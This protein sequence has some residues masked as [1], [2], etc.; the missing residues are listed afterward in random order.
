L[1][2]TPLPAGAT[3]ATSL[4]VGWAVGVPSVVTGV[5][6]GVTLG[7]SA[8]L[9]ATAEKYRQRENYTLEALGNT[10]DSMQ[11]KRLHAGK[12][13]QTSDGIA[14]M[15]DEAAP[16]LVSL[17][18]ARRARVISEADA[19]ERASAFAV[20]CA[21]DELP[22]EE[23]LENAE[24]AGRELLTYVKLQECF[25]QDTP[26]VLQEAARALAEE[27]PDACDAAWI[28]CGSKPLSE[29]SKKIRKVLPKSAVDLSPNLLT[30]GLQ[31]KF[32][33][34]KPSLVETLHNICS[35]GTKDDY[36][37]IVSRFHETLPPSSFW[38][39]WQ[40]LQRPDIAEVFQ[41]LKY[42]QLA[43]PEFMYEFQKTLYSTKVLDTKAESKCNEQVQRTL[44][45]T[46]TRG[47]SK[48]NE[49]G[50]VRVEILRAVSLSDPE[51]R[52]GDMTS[53][54]FGAVG[55][56]SNTMHPYV[57]VSWGG[58]AHQTRTCDTSSEGNADI[59]E[60]FCFPLKEDLE[61]A[62]RA[63]GKIAF[64]AFDARSAQA[65]V[66]GDPL[67]GAGEVMLQ[68]KTLLE[69]SVVT[70]K[71]KRDGATHGQLKIRFAYR[72]PKQE[73]EVLCQSKDRPL[74]L[75]LK[76]MVHVLR[77]PRGL[78]MLMESRPL[79]TQS[80]DTESMRFMLQDWIGQ[81]VKNVDRL[82]A[83]AS[84]K[85]T[86]QHMSSMSASVQIVVS[87]CVPPGTSAPQ[88]QA[89]AGQ[90]IRSFLSAA[91]A[92]LGQTDKAAATEMAQ[93]DEHRLKLIMQA[94]SKQ[95]KQSR[96][97]NPISSNMV[98]PTY[99][100][101]QSL[102]RGEQIKIRTSHLDDVFLQ[103]LR[104]SATHQHC[105]GRDGTF[106][107]GD[108]KR[109]K[110]FR[111]E[112]T[113]TWIQYKNKV[114]ELKARFEAA[115]SKCK[116]LQ[117]PVPAHMYIDGAEYDETMNEVFLWHA[118][119][120]EIADVIIKEGVD[121]RVCS[122]GGLFGAGVYFAEES[123]KSGQYAKK[124]QGKHYFFLSRVCLGRPYYATTCMNSTR[125]AP[126]GSDCVIANVGSAINL[127]HR[128]LI[129]YDRFQA[130]PEFLIEA[131]TTDEGEFGYF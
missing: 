69:G 5:A 85:E 126:D 122:L 97:L 49:T 123:C 88:V 82:G 80:V 36:D 66:R 110:S 60:S 128:E 2:Q 119:K 24:A 81:F 57:E 16:F 61:K 98:A 14:E 114:E 121:E 18:V 35:D 59:G 96:N 103:Q 95:L 39:L 45:K 30:R 37:A 100:L 31:L 83:D 108:I 51:Y 47:K 91:A 58:T 112:N 29:W 26:D 129:V 27:D 127:G 11:Q 22:P 46:L 113:I 64:Q 107:I 28:V 54:L 74:A 63:N 56:G 115:G 89:I 9:L 10:V 15:P 78:D 102:K 43:S 65:A 48:A 68:E 125:R 67:F 21:V 23:I 8:E 33:E 117:P 72:P 3:N 71:L 34:V 75:V 76:C 86:I 70:V 1:Y 92:W 42:E 38:K 25:P 50:E 105:S 52:I 109:V 124:Y 101:N 106:N 19:F 17:A 130:Y 41:D 87:S 131:D 55:L 120:H 93:I 118:T 7:G 4:A 73:Q 62:I 94:G 111:L 6:L 104:R 90:W 77:Q 116:P 84:D 99:W 20:K 53:S 13:G 32:V 40:L 12:R 44:S 79:P